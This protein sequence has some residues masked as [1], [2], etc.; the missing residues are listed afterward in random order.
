MNSLGFMSSHN[1][2][3]LSFPSCCST[4]AVWLLHAR[5]P[6]NWLLMWACRKTPQVAI[7]M[8]RPLCP[9]QADVDFHIQNQFV[10]HRRSLLV[11][12]SSSLQAKIWRREGQGGRWPHSCQCF[13]WA[14][15]GSYN[16]IYLNLNWQIVVDNSYCYYNLYYFQHLSYACGDLMVDASFMQ[17]LW[18][19]TPVMSGCELAEGTEFCCYYKNV[20]GQEPI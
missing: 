18:T 13:F 6:T 5:W 17:T 14:I 10:H 7:K 4:W 12:H 9:T 2:N 3:S 15:P 19:M 16:F 8:H 11:D 1:A 20:F